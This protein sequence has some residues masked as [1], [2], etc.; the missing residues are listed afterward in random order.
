MPVYGLTVV[1]A[2]AGVIVANLGANLTVAILSGA[3]ILVM[4]GSLALAR[5]A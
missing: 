4:L 2:L 1:W 5:R 3:G